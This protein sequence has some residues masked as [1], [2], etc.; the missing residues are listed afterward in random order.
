MSILKLVGL[1]RIQG[2]LF[3]AASLDLILAADSSLK[4]I[5]PE[6]KSALHNFSEARNKAFTALNNEVVNLLGSMKL[7]SDVI[8]TDTGEAIQEQLNNITF[9]K[10]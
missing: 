1:N 6:I 4:D 7:Q 3:A 5:S 8:N 2:N 9:G 10:T